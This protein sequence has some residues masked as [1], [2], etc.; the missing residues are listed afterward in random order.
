MDESSINDLAKQM[1]QK[2]YNN[3]K[4]KEKKDFDMKKCRKDTKK[5]IK[6]NMQSKNSGSGGSGSTNNKT[7]KK[8]FWA[9]KNGNGYFQIWSIVVGDQ[10]FPQQAD[11]GVSIANWNKGDVTPK[12]MTWGKVAFAQAEFYYDQS[13]DWEDM[14]E[15]AMWNM[16]WRARLRRVRTP[17]PTVASM[18][19]NDVIGA[20]VGKLSPT[21]AAALGGGEILGYVLG[22]W[23][24]GKFEKMLGQ[25]QQSGS[26]KFNGSYVKNPKLQSVGPIDIIH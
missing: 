6:K 11:K 2:S 18:L 7:S 1:C 24:G 14:K 21:V 23:G 15:D 3:A 17:A 13:G 8:V 9:A 25:I 26:S 22:N 10:Q 19:L 5:N 16:R 4:G 20:I 12:N